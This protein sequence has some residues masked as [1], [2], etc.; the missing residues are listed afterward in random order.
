MDLLLTSFA[1]V[2]VIEGL[3]Y[4]IFPAHIQ[5]MMALAL[6]MPTEKIRSFGAL[7]LLSGAI[8]VWIMKHV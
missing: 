7:M 6:T 8:L 1:M 2:F 4:A 3:L 5:K